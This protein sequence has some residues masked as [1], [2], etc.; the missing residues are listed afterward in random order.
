MSQELS[1]G[2]QVGTMTCDS[3]GADSACK[4]F[5]HDDGKRDAY[6][7]KCETYHPLDR[8]K[9]N[10]VSIQSVKS[11]PMT[12][13][14]RADIQGLPTLELADRGIRKEIAEHF[15]V[16]CALSE[17]DGK[18]VTHHYYP[19]R[20]AGKIVGYEV[21]KIEGK[22]FSA[23]GNRKGTL[24]LWGQHQLTGGNKLFITE[25]RCDAMALHQAIIDNRPAKYAQYAPSVVSITKGVSHAMK[26]LMGNR[27]FLSKFKEVILCF[28]QDDAGKKACREVLKVFPLF[29]VAKFPLK[30]PNAMLLEGRGKELYAA[31]VFEAQVVRQG[32]VVDIDDILTKCM[33]RPKMGIPFPWKAV[34]KATFGVRPHTIHVVAAAPKIGKTDWQHQLVH[35]LTFNEGVKVGMFDL[36]NSPVRTAK[37]LASKEA[38]FDFTRPD[39]EYDDQLLHDTLVSLQGKVRFYDRGASRDWS[40]I[41][42]A[43]EEMH[44]LDG[45]N[46]F[47]IDPITALISR[48]SS[49]EANDKLNEICT[50]MADLVNSYP[51]TLFCFSH[52][53]PKPKTSKPHEEGGKVYS[54]EMTGSRAMEKWF[55]YGHGISRNRTDEC[56]IEEKNMSKFYALFDREY[57]QSYNTDV[58]FDEDTVT[59][60]EPKG[61]FG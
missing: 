28:D 51:I 14:T 12:S 53:N 20:L 26:D 48:Y 45:I 61:V 54:S 24:D 44:L 40:D 34:T 52:V 55:H 46:I 22:Q 11:E 36:E 3:C 29:K 59:Y 25:G 32:E 2:R 6:C 5:E 8:T 38:R 17:R 4:V 19:D 9:E 43:I 18:T 39:K 13:E 15:G 21:R 10:V 27:D 58:Y 50:D 42:V 57:G 31:C 60:L 56:P 41:R 33:E 30:D 37:K 23:V 1:R 35:H 7:F 49:S 16:K 47:M